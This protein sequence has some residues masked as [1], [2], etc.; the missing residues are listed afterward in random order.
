VR[1]RVRRQLRHAVALE[2]REAGLPSGWYLIGATAGA[3]GT[4]GA[5][6]RAAVHG[7]IENI[8]RRGMS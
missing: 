4:D 2:G 7:L 8:R 3:A 6:M 5:V 1:N